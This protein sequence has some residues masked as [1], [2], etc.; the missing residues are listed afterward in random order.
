MYFTANEHNTGGHFYVEASFR[1]KESL[2]KSENLTSD[3]EKNDGESGSG[4]Y[5][6]G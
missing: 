5:I 1:L 6:R 2:E 3:R 4:K